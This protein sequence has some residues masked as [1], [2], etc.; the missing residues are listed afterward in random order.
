MFF[1]F[2]PDQD[3]LRR[4][5]EEAAKRDS[6]AQAKKEGPKMY[7]TSDGA[8]VIDDPS[9]VGDV[10]VLNEVPSLESLQLTSMWIPNVINE[11]GAF[12]AWVP[13]AKLPWW[14]HHAQEGQVNN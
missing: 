12:G 11:N 5:Q 1:Q 9:L 10:K 13:L 6:E 7:Q 4:M 8:V 14:R 2:V 3:T